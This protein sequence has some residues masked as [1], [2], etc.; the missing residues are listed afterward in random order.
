MDDDMA[1]KLIHC[2]A[3]QTRSID[4]LTEGV[5]SIAAI[6]E[7]GTIHT[8]TSTSTSTRTAERQ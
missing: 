4:R 6:L 7:E 2:I 1:L 3:K 5:N 8:S